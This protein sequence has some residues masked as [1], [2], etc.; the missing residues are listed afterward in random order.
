MSPEDFISL[1]EKSPSFTRK[2]NGAM[3]QFGP[4]AVSQFI[5]RLTPNDI[6]TLADEPISHAEK[7]RRKREKKTAQGVRNAAA[8]G[9]ALAGLGAFAGGFARLGG[10]AASGA[11]AVEGEILGPE[12]SPEMG[13][14]QSPLPN[15]GQIEGPEQQSPSGPL[16]SSPIPPQPEQPTS[17]VQ[18]ALQDIDLNALDEGKLRQIGALARK[19][20][21][22]EK[23]GKGPNDKM[24]KDLTSRIK[25]LSSSSLR[26]S[27]MAR[28]TEAYGNVEDRI[29]QQEAER[30]KPTAKKSEKVLDVPAL[31]IGDL[32]ETKAGQNGRVV[33]VD[34]ERGIAK[35]KIDKKVYT[36]KIK[37]LTQKDWNDLKSA[38][39]EEHAYSPELNT[40]LLKFR[41]GPWY[42][43]QD[44]DEESYNRFS[45]GKG[46]AKTT[47]EANGIKWWKGKNPSIGAAFWKEIRDKNPYARLDETVDV[48]YFFSNFDQISPDLPW[49]IPEPK[50]K[51]RKKR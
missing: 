47:G 26:E 32:V 23:K 44:V 31:E 18:Q 34:E 40:A 3:R 4:Q 17:I 8:I 30:L 7:G 2:I 10:A 1:L 43:Y 24:V 21:S 16:P 39:I 37:D 13:S 45:K 14:P 27:E 9:G 49:Q 11:Q 42:G 51:K 15:Q 46:T 22:L 28:T 50:K 41:K 6:Y 12:Q 29:N 33:E 5:Q 20:E 48:D 35:V 19:L 38:V 36:K 25:A